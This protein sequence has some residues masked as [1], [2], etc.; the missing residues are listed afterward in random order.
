VENFWKKGFNNKYNQYNKNKDEARRQL[1]ALKYEEENQAANT[2]QLQHLES[3]GTSSK[4]IRAVELEK[5]KDLPFDLKEINAQK[6]KLNSIKKDLHELKEEY[7]MFQIFAS[8][9]EKRRK[10]F[11]IGY[12]LREIFRTREYHRT[13]QKRSST[14]ALKYLID[15]DS[16]NTHEEKVKL[17]REVRKEYNDLSIGWFKYK[18]EFDKGIEVKFEA[19]LKYEEKKLINHTQ[20]TK[21]VVTSGKDMREVKFETSENPSFHLD[22]INV[23]KEK[24]NGIK[25]ELDELDDGMFQAFALDEDKQKKWFDIGYQLQQLY[26]NKNEDIDSYTKQSIKDINRQFSK[27]Y[28]EILHEGREVQKI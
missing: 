5:S 22:E 21:R 18:Q 16:S 4:D 26:G 6:Q 28:Y 3:I 13:K 9:K 27:N 10:L 25:K 19:T 15:K 23:R 14:E 8:V 11:A 1:E 2:E 17:G 7:G 20:D 12:Q 24:L